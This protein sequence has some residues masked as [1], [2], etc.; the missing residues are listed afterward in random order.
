MVLYAVDW[1]KKIT[2][3]T[4]ILTSK[5]KHAAVLLAALKIVQISLF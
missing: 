1:I 3:I 5:P 2:A 4:S